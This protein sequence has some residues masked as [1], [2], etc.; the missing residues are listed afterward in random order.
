MVT[1][2]FAG[3]ARINL[4]INKNIIILILVRTL[5]YESCVA[6]QRA[7]LRGFLSLGY[8]NYKRKATPKQSGT[9]KKLGRAI[10][11]HA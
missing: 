7:H 6:K 3:G 8:I 2:I 1:K 5:R 9:E 11:Q 4:K 10:T